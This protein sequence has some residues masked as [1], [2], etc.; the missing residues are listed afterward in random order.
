M[1]IF[2]IMGIAVSML[3]LNGCFKT[4]TPKCSDTQV[5]VMVKKIYADHMKETSSN[6]IFAQVLIATVPKSIRLIH[7]EP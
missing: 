1:K 7:P 5:T 4:E 2:Y 6:N 3:I